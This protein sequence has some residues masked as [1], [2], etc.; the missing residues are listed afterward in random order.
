M[1][2]D[3]RLYRNRNDSAVFLDAKAKLIIPAESGL[4]ILG[5]VLQDLAFPLLD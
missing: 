5:T 4:I 2:S 1:A 3:P